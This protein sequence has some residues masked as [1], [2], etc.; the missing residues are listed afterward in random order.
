M[1]YKVEFKKKYP[2]FKWLLSVSQYLSQD[3]HHSAPVDLTNLVRE[4]RRVLTRCPTEKNARLIRCEASEDHD[5]S[6]EVWRKEERG[7]QRSMERAQ[8]VVE[9]FLLSQTDVL[10]FLQ[11]RFI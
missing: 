9:D 5:G 1:W 4:S 8:C 2:E 7:T 6:K 3:C 10:T 11:R